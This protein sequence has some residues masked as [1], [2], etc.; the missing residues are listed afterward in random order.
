MVRRS[1]ELRVDERFR[2]VIEYALSELERLLGDDLISVVLFGSVARGDFREGSDIDIL[3]VAR[4]FP[5]SYSRR[6]SLLVPIAE[7]ARR[8]VPEHPIQ[9]YPLR[10]DEAS[11]TRPIYLDLLTDSV[12]LYD[13]DGFMQGVLRDLSERLAKLGAKKVRLEDGSWMWVLKPG[14]RVGEVIDI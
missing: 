11:K 14:L 12:I 2:E 13:R 5:K 4:S 7:G 10:V 9:F 6:I 8:R 3:V 1:E